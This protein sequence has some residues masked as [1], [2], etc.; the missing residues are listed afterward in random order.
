LPAGKF[1]DPD[2]SNLGRT[3]RIAQSG[4]RLPTP[5]NDNDDDNEDS[6]ND[7]DN[8]EDDNDDSGDNVTQPPGVVSSEAPTDTMA[9][10]STSHPPKTE[11]KRR[12]RLRSSVD[13]DYPI[14]LELRL[15]LVFGEAPCRDTVASY[16]IGVSRGRMEMVMDFV[17]ARCSDWEGEWDVIPDVPE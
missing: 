1:H 12:Q 3:A 6:D 10:S 8:D 13:E 15:Q 11:R 17:A 16:W 4:L 14:Y 2:G 9:T 5:D 7:H